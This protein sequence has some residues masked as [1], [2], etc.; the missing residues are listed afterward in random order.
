LAITF[1][2]T[3]K[4][5]IRSLI[6]AKTKDGLILQSSNF[7]VN[8]DV[9]EVGADGKTTPLA[10]GEYTISFTTPEGKDNTQVIDVDGGKIAGISSVSEAADETAGTDEEENEEKMDDEA[11]TSV[12]MA[13]ADATTEKAKS[14][15][16]TTD[17]DKANVHKDGD[18]EEQDGVIRMEDMAE[19]LGKL[20]MAH[21]DLM[22]KLS[23]VYGM[24]A[25]N[26]RMTPDQGV[27]PLTPTNMAEID[28]EELPKLD[29]A[30]IEAPVKFSALENHKNFGKKDTG[31]YHA[32][33]LSKM[34]K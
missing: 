31:N 18:T 26:N 13:A 10:D 32:S 2:K 16:N 15:P 30:P 3:T 4:N 33:V 12:A 19:R 23:S 34:Y 5:S 20:E 1:R 24:D 25:L 21:K 17:E 28:E 27:E 9:M 7:D 22:D 11:A 14:L 29:G 6:Q 8:D